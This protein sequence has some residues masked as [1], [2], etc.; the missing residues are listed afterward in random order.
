MT[1]FYTYPE[2]TPSTSTQDKLSKNVAKSSVIKKNMFKLIKVLGKAVKVID[3]I[4]KAFELIDNGATI[5]DFYQ[6]TL[7]VKKAANQYCYSFDTSVNVG[8]DKQKVRC[9]N[10]LGKYLFHLTGNTALLTRYPKYSIYEIMN[11]DPNKKDEKVIGTDNAQKLINKRSIP[12]DFR[13]ALRNILKKQNNSNFTEDIIEPILGEADYAWKNKIYT[14]YVKIYNNLAFNEGVLIN[15][16]NLKN[17]TSVLYS[18]KIKE[19]NSIGLVSF[20]SSFIVKLVD[21]DGKTLLK[22]GDNNSAWNKPDFNKATKKLMDDLIKP[23]V[24]N[25]NL[26]HPFPQ[27]QAQYPSMK[28]LRDYLSKAF[29]WHHDEETLDEMVL[30]PRFIH[31]RISHWGASNILEK[32]QKNLK[33]REQWKSALIYN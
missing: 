32:S 3:F 16:I 21:S 22:G 12:A 27:T 13:I 20:N 31:N 14:E 24:D 15:K 6:K 23:S 19:R 26:N 5:V 2:S 28:V 17:R 1:T 29:T 18:P 10:E 7:P 30:V 11:A 8:T 9:L 25:Y 4:I 33:W